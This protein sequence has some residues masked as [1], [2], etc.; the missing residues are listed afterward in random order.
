M[1]DQNGELAAMLGRDVDGEQWQAACDL[2]ASDATDD[3]VE[4][5]VT[6]RLAMPLTDAAGML[7]DLKSLADKI[8]AMSGTLKDKEDPRTKPFHQG[9]VPGVAYRLRPAE[10]YLGGS[11]S[12]Q[13]S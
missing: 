3:L 8:D 9:P 12:E 6:R 10:R 5:L 1:I 13:E 7:D 4:V 2:R 11:T